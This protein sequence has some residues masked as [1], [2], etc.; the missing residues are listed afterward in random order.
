MVT[1]HNHVSLYL[2]DDD[3]DDGESFSLSQQRVLGLKAIGHRSSPANSD[4]SFCLDQVKVRH[5]SL[6]S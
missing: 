1:D 5:L 3:N 2:H 6:G 4:L